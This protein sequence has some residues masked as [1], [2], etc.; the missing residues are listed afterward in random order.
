MKSKIERRGETDYLVFQPEGFP[1]QFMLPVITKGS[2]RDTNC[3]TWNGNLDKPTLKPSIKQT[4]T[5]MKGFKRQDYQPTNTMIHF[6][7]N[8]GVCQ[9]L[10][11]C[12]DGNAGN[13][14]PLIDLK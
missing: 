6:W 1:N 2:R 8:D 11:D 4:Y 14:M 12:T 7:L 13:C 5:D 3:W 9:C 10:D